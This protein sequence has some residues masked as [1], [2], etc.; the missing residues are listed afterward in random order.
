M[1][2][3]YVLKLSRTGSERCRIRT[4]THNYARTNRNKRT[5]SRLSRD[6]FLRVVNFHSEFTLFPPFYLNRTWFSADRSKLFAE[7]V[8]LSDAVSGRTLLRQI[9][10]PL[11]AGQWRLVFDIITATEISSRQPSAKLQAPSAKRIF[12]AQSYFPAYL[13]CPLLP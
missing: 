5:K 10:N 8:N 1:S 4:N 3:S 12:M 2:P 13:P 7:L 6:L 11:R 9:A